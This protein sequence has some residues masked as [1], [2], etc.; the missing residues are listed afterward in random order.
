MILR[1][2]TQHVK[3]QNWFAVGV[4]FLIVV[5]GILIAF[6]ITNWNERQ[7]STR[8]AERLLATLETDLQDLRKRVN[9][10][11]DFSYQTTV[12]LDALLTQLENGET[13]DQQVV[14]ATISDA[15]NMY[16]IGEP[17]I[18]FQEMMT[19]GKLDLLNSAKLRASLRDFFDLTNRNLSAN[20]YLLDEFSDSY[21]KLSHF[22]V[23][24]RDPSLILD[25]FFLPV[26]DVKIES[27][28]DEPEA[29]IALKAVYNIH[30]N[31]QYLTQT[32]L[33]SIDAI[34]DEIKNEDAE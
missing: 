33:I 24:Q 30:V 1:R 5:L 23:I 34:L 31:L 6:Q 15:Q 26:I 25:R 9:D 28:W 14:I 8:Q 7:V 27:L 29:Q 2:I 22:F 17:P 11:K 3:E 21:K 12:T 19:S 10:Q 4:D 32:T 18:S 16:I 20:A 13:L